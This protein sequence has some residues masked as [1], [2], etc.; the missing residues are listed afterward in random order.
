M[1]KGE[2]GIIGIYALVAGILQVVQWCSEAN[3]LRRAGDPKCR[4]TLQGFVY[5]DIVE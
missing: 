2:R 5:R 4:R 1:I 3:K